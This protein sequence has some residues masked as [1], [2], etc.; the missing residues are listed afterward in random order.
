MGKACCNLG[1]SAPSEHP[2][3][4]HIVEETPDVDVETQSVN[5][6]DDSN[7]VKTSNTVNTSSTAVVI[8]TSI[9]PGFV[10]HVIGVHSFK[11]TKRI[12]SVTLYINYSIYAVLLVGLLLF[13]MFMWLC[14]M[15]G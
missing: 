4:F 6:V 9:V 11:K 12:L 8:L 7:T 15:Y 3:D 1:G 14:P 10:I 5:T 13:L 2:T